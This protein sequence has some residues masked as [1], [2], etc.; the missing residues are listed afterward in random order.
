M[1]R[2]PTSDIGI[3]LGRGETIHFMVECAGIDP[4]QHYHLRNPTYI[5]APIPRISVPHNTLVYLLRVGSFYSD[6]YHVLTFIR[7]ILYDLH[8]LRNDFL[9]VITLLCT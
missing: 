9:E 7:D 4:F 3:S 2:I 5:A 1:N 8:Q 6:L